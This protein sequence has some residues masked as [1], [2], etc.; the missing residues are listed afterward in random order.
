MPAI[1]IDLTSCTL[2]HRLCLVLAHRC[3][4][5]GSAAQAADVGPER[6]ADYFP[7]GWSQQQVSSPVP[8][9][10]GVCLTAGPTSRPHCVILG[11]CPQAFRLR[12]SAALANGRSPLSRQN[13]PGARAVHI[14]VLE[15]IGLLS[16]VVRGLAS[17]PFLIRLCEDDLPTDVDEAGP[18]LFRMTAPA[19]V[20]SRRGPRDRIWKLLATLFLS[21]LRGAGRA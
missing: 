13:G 9:C 11:C 20:A 19:A 4:S 5:R 8:P 16:G 12:K 17:G 3:R 1:P 6:Q 21:R 10:L 7:A 2:R 14:E 15:V 18:C